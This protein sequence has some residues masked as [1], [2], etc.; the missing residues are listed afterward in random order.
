MSHE[1][2]AWFPQ[3][4]WPCNPLLLLCFQQTSF[5]LARWSPSALGAMCCVFLVSKRA[6]KPLFYP[7]NERMF[8]QSNWTNLDLTSLPGPMTVT[9]G[10]PGADWILDYNT[11][12]K[13]TYSPGT[14]VAGSGL[15]CHMAWME[16]RRRIGR[17]VDIVLC[18][19]VFNVSMFNVS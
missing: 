13:L 6:R 19:T 1:A 11:C 5:V 18:L 8:L 3:D 10:M 15:G 9:R 12:R 16:E 17:W 14:L 2:R 4:L 7:R